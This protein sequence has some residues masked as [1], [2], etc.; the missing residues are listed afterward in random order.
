[1]V[2]CNVC[3]GRRLLAP[4]DRFPCLSPQLSRLEPLLG[5]GGGGGST[6]SDRWRQYEQ[7]IDQ[8]QADSRQLTEQ[9]Q[10]LRRQL[11]TMTRQRDKLVTGQSLSASPKITAFFGCL[12]GKLELQKVVRVES[13]SKIWA[14]NL[15]DVENCYC[16][17]SHCYDGSSCVKEVA[18]GK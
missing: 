7:T 8:L 11:A 10:L 3:C 2:L 6:D 14:K 1:M 18:N 15:L 13:W 16:H 9:L 17:F 12:S 5:G 4:T